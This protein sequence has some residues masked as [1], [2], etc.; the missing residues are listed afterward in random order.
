[1]LGICKRLSSKLLF[2]KFENE[3]FN[4]I[5]TVNEIEGKYT[6]TMLLTLFALRF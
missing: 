5:T 1:M 6:E 4:L 3:N 2:L